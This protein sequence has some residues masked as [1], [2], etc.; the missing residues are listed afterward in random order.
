MRNN[1]MSQKTDQLVSGHHQP[2]KYD[3]LCLLQIGLQS[4]QAWYQVRQ[5]TER[6]TEIVLADGALLQPSAPGEVTEGATAC[7]KEGLTPPARG[8]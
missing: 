4:S 2:A 1:S 3:A 7:A 5:L 8:A 6:T